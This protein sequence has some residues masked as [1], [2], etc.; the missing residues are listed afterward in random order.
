MFLS[1]ALANVWGFSLGALANVLTTGSRLS[2]EVSACSTTMSAIWEWLPSH[3]IDDQ[4]INSI[5]C[6]HIWWAVSRSD[7][8]WD[9]L[10]HSI[11]CSH[12]WWAVSRSNRPLMNSLDK[13][14]FM[15]TYMMNAIMFVHKDMYVRKL[16]KGTREY[17]RKNVLIHQNHYRKAS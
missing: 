11:S 1:K 15:V 17:L 10:I 5:S 6:S 14:Y 12:I 7:R 3:G 2:R 13:Q 8:P 9:E 4:L 16:F